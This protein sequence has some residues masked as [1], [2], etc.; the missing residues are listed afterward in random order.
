VPPRAATPFA[1]LVPL[2]DT[3]GLDRDGVRLPALAAPLGTYLGWNLRRPASR[4][5]DRL[6]RWQGS[7][8]PFPAT[9]ND[10]RDSDDPRRSISERYASADGFARETLAAAEALTRDRLL[11]A[12]DVAPIVERARDLYRRIADQAYADCRPTGDQ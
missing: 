2:P 6:G 7:F 9:R 3:D 8:I 5:M 4:M 10:R 1:T 12:S 11:L